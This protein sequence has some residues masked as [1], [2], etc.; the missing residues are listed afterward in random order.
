M[1]RRK[2]FTLIELLVVIAIIGLLST[3]AVVS[4]NSVREK[5][6]DA[7]R[8]SDVKQISTALEIYY[9]SEGTYVTCSEYIDPVD[10]D[11]NTIFSTGCTQIDDDKFDIP[12]ASQTEF[13]DPDTDAVAVPC[14]NADRACN[15]TI[16]YMGIDEYEICFRLE[17]GSG[18]LGS[19]A[20]SIGTAGILDSTCNHPFAAAPP[21]P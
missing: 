21:R 11:D 14:T 4:L 20:A 10:I 8:I 5:A 15:Y 1:I 9:T 3:L 6:R 17:S 19:G 18:N 13:A 12:G 7:N 2:G 16:T